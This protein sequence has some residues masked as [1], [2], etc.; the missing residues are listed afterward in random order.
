LYR[1]ER[2]VVAQYGTVAANSDRMN[3]RIPANFL[4]AMAASQAIK[5][6]IAQSIYLEKYHPE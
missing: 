4:I 5:T 3:E 6:S 1:P 2:R